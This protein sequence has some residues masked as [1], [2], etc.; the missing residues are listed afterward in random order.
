MATQNINNSPEAT[1]IAST[2]DIFISKGGT[3]L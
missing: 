2:D 3:A 1:A